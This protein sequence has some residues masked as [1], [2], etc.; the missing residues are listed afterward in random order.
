MRLAVV[1]PCRNEAERLPALVI[2]LS[3]QSRRPDE[4]VLVDDRSTDGTVACAEALAVRF[5]SL[6]LRVVPGPGR[7]PG[8]AMNAGIRVTGAD[9][10][11]RLD[12]HSVP[13]QDYLRWSEEALSHDEIGVVGGIWHIAPGRDTAAARAIAAVV[14]HPIGS[15][16][17]A[18]R[19]DRARE[20]LQESVDTVPFGAFRRALWERLGGYDDTLEVNEDYD[21]NYRTRCLGLRVILD[22][23]IQ[24]TYFARPSLGLLWQQYRRYG[25]WKA[26][27]LR[28]DPRALAPRQVP[29][30]AL[31]P[32]LMGLVMLAIAVPHASTAGLS[33]LYPVAMAAVAAGIAHE[34][35]VA[36]AP[37][38][39]A[40][41]TVHVAW[42]LG[43]WED[44]LLRGLKR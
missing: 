18:Y 26:E 6:Q 25:F 42:S 41:F 16:G 33:A 15:G 7:G 36:W 35:R 10:I 12:A 38:L 2:A 21:F 39:S 31:V 20:P 8:Q 40:I 37:T 34:R 3:T 1:I 9:L 23:R 24:S 43:V 30:M 4:V 29:P 19:D 44:L 14:S 17:A 5:P 32:G 11:V 13:A 22:R 27:M 28:K